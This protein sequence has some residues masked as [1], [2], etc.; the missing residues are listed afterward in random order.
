MG[1]KKIGLVEE[2]QG[3]GRDVRE[4]E[5][6]EEG[7]EGGPGVEEGGEGKNQ[8]AKVGRGNSGLW[9]VGDKRSVAGKKMTKK[10]EPRPGSSPQ[11]AVGDSLLSSSLDADLLHLVLGLSETRRIA[12]DDLDAGDV[13]RDGNDVARRPWDGRD[14]GGVALGEVIE[15]GRLQSS[16]AEINLRVQ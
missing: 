9:N 4:D 12:E 14:N 1:R 3:V 7:G 5:R 6:G 10:T 2:D 15:E 16:R 8:K 13:E 11:R